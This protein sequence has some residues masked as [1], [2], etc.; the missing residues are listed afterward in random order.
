MVWPWTV[1]VKYRTMSKDVELEM[2]ILQF[3]KSGAHCMVCS[4][5]MTG[6]QRTYR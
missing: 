1:G 5:E 4:Q 3:H 6:Y 2:E